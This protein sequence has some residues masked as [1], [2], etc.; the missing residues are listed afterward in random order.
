[1]AG[2]D[3][4]VD[5]NAIRAFAKTVQGWAQDFPALRT[6]IVGINV[7]PGAFDHGTWLK[8]QVDTHKNQLGTNLDNL[9]NA[10]TELGTRLNEIV[11]MYARTEDLNKLDAD[12]LQNLVNGVNK[13]LPVGTAVIPPKADPGPPAPPA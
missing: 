11:D 9:Q 4:K 8:Q 10:L 2:D 5:G 3:I 1:M 12:K 6:Q 7:S 13:Y